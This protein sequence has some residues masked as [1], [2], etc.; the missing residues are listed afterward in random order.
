MAV[1]KLFGAAVKRR[2]DPRL[3][4]GR[5]NFTDHIRLPGT[6]VMAIKRSPHA[7]A[8][9]VRIDTSKARAMP[10][11]VAVYT[12]QDLVDKLA[13]V[14]CAWLIPDSDLKVPPYRAVA[15]DKVRYVGDAVA[16]V[17][18]EN[19]YIAQ[20]AVEAI[21][22]EYEPLPAV[23]DQEKALEPGA[24]QLYDDV[25]NNLAFHWKLHAGDFEAAWNAA[26]VRVS[27]RLINHRLIPTA[28]EPRGALAAYNPG[29][30][31][32]T[33]W[34]T[35]QNPHVHRLLLSAVTGLPETQIRV[36]AT[37][38]GGGFGSKIPMYAGEMI[39]AAISKDL[40]RPIKWI[41]TRQENYVA[42][43]HG[44]DHIQY[45]DIAAK[46]DGTI[47][48]VRV[49]AYAN[50]GAYLSTAAPGVPTWLFGLMLQGAYAIPVVHCDVYG[51]LTNTTPT[52]AYRG[53]GRPEA[54]YLLERMI[55]LLAR[56]LGMDPAEIR[57]KNFIPKDKFPYTTPT[58]LQYDSG[59]YEATLDKALEL[60]DYQNLRRQQAELR[61]QGRYIGIGFSTYVEVCGLAPSQAAG[62]MGFQGGLWES[63]TVR[64][65]PTGKVT[66]F[67]GSNPHGQGEETTFAQLVADE[68]GVPFEDVEIVHGDT[69]MVPFGMGT[70][71]S[72]ST[73]VGGAALVHACRKVKEKAQRIAAHLLEVS[74]EDLAFENG[75]FFVKGAPDRG[76]TFQ[77]VAL[78]AYLAWKLPREIEPGLEATHF[79]DPINN[80]FPFG[81]HICVVEVDPETGKVQFLKYVAVDDVGNVINPMIV[82]G[83]VHG[84][85]AQGLAQAV[86]EFAAYDENGQLLSASLMDYAIPKASM[87]PSFTVDR[88]VTPTPVNPMGIKGAGETG[89]IASTPAVVNAVID[90]L[91]P[92]GIDHIDMPLTP[93][94]IWRA[95][96]ERSR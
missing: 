76:M 52:D 58:G 85:I 92:F 15:V 10:G 66:V 70:Y 5:G 4:T 25:P 82:D 13:P 96:R 67:T 62:A 1:T 35:S 19:R 74:P 89:T 9:I 36:I 18:A 81:C 84:G 22:V 55:D 27:R 54:T 44:R 75:R 41:E 8:R 26:E 24:P 34:C 78:Q 64:V 61:Q 42:T 39:A 91:A 3:I 77:E 53:A 43:I 28:M 69:E 12:G 71:G 49:R 17:V 33:I 45:V 80:T 86:Y 46:R 87:L 37:D 38:V 29:T 93:E 95:I 63:A 23:V 7:H 2:E 60:V 16:V 32:L 6:L 31:E 51:V 59:D 21:E 40:G 68:L 57:R 65:H 48:G 11:V 14:P 83:Q 50:M 47:T 88:T 56:E 73:A 72:R 94:R 79:F 30:G 90:A 20:D